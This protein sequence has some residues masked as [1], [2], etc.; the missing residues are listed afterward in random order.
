MIFQ[1]ILTIDTVLLVIIIVKYWIFYDS[2][3][4]RPWC[5]FR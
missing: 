2:D 5:L 3:I 1:Y 4:G